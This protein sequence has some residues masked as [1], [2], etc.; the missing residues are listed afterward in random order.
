MNFGI[1]GEQYLKATVEDEPI[2][3]VAAYAT[4]NTIGGFQ[5]YGFDVLLLK[6]ASSRKAG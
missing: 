5:Q 6:H 4:T 3:V 2:N 1:R